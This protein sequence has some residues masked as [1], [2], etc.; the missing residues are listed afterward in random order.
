MQISTIDHNI[1]LDIT[2]INFSILLRGLDTRWRGHGLYVI[3][4]CYLQM[5]HAKGEHN[6]VLICTQYP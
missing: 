4:M 1:I 3:I 5:G 2:M 6:N